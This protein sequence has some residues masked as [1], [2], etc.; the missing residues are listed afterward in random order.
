M[1]ASERAKEKKKKKKINNNKKKKKMKITIIIII[2]AVAVVKAPQV[3]CATTDTA[4]SKVFI[5]EAARALR[6]EG[7]GKSKFRLVNY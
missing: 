5:R 3:P 1:R 6:G 7:L 2:T 4:P